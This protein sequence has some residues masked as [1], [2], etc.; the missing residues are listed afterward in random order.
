M[1]TKRPKELTRRFWKTLTKREKN[2]INELRK[3][4][5]ETY[6]KILQDA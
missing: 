6:H 2:T 1:K 4:D 5:I 3:Q